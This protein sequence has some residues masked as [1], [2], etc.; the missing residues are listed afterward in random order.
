[1]KRNFGKKVIFTVHGLDWAR[2]KWQG[3][4]G[5]KYIR[6]GEKMGVKY[7]DEIIALSDKIM[8]S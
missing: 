1:M 7:A 8:K 5:K 3:G 6:L 4:F 2:E